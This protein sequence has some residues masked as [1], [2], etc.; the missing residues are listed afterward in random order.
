[1]FLHNSSPITHNLF[2]QVRDKGQHAQVAGAFHSGGYAALVLEA[3]A[4]NAA[5]QQFALLVNELEQKF[6]IFVVDILDTEFAEAAVFFA[7][8]TDFRIAEEFY[9]FSRSSHIV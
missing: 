2:K 8:Q 9:V 1:M 7:S 4:R 5:R 6:R 3:I